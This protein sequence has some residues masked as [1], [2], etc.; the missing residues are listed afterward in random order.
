ME[1][2]RIF[3]NYLNWFYL[4]HYLLKKC[5]TNYITTMDN[6]NDAVTKHRVY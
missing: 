3:K 1:V 4:F 6:Q 2:V 5:Y